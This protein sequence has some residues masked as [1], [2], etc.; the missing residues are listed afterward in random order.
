LGAGRGADTVE[1]PV[2]TPE[3][4]KAAYADIFKLLTMDTLMRFK[5][6]L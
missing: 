6:T 1:P 5:K 3:M 2:A 4:W